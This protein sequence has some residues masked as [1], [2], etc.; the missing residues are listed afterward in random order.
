MH[1]RW[2]LRND[3]GHSG[4]IDRLDVPTGVYEYAI[5]GKLHGCSKY[6]IAL[7]VKMNNVP[8]KDWLFNVVRVLT[9]ADEGRDTIPSDIH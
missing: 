5:K 1:S 7:G 4:T 9:E 2:F 6:A 8:K 3:E